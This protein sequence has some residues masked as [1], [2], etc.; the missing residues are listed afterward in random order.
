MFF[1]FIESKHNNTLKTHINKTIRDGT[2]PSLDGLKEQ[3]TN[4]HQKKADKVKSD[5][6]KEKHLVK[7]KLTEK[8]ILIDD[9]EDTIERWNT[10][11]GTGI[12]YKSA[13]Q[14]LNDLKKLGL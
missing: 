10:A 6:A 13:S 2:K 1:Q 12:H 7:D 9:R 3:I 4:H 14:V 11:G 5:A 8:D